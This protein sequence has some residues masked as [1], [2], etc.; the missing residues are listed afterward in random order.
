MRKASQL[1][2][3]S[4]AALYLVFV[5]PLSPS[6]LGNSR[7]NVTKTTG[8]GPAVL[9]HDPQ[10]ISTRNL[11]Y[12]PGGEADQPQGTL[13]FVKEDMEG[14]NPKFDATDQNGTKWKVKMGVEARPE[15]VAARLV[16]AVGYYADED[17]FLPVVRV[18]EMPRLHRGHKYVAP[19]GT[20]ANVRLKRNP[21]DGKKI[22]TWEWAEDPFTG[23]REW[24]ALRVLMAV[25]N[26]WD[27]KDENNAIIQIRGDQPE[28]LY[29][30]SD[31]GASFGKIGFGWTRSGSKGNLKAYTHSKFI[32]QMTAEE[33][34]FYVP[35]RPALDHYPE[36]PSLRRRLRLRWIG[37][38]IPR[39]DARWMGDLL[40][41][42]SPQQIRDAFR[43]AQYSDHDV[44]G[45]SQVVEKRIAELRSL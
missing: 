26:N 11:F 2:T 8:E 16:W 43:A 1:A 28:Q 30:V 37:R 34:T 13:T 15:T 32:K 9:W 3:V 41:R 20:V 38:D 17:Y 40:G 31:L 39:A 12:G 29:L 10:D 24:N 27:L 7:A 45:F 36:I 35:S 33:V 22:G 23:T 42:L 14:S 25:I 19:D 18:K 21:E 4:V 44:E 6:K 5:S